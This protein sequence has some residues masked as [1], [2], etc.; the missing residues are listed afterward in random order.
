VT[1]L[2]VTGAELVISD[3]MQASEIR[4]DRNWV[5]RPLSCR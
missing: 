4:F 5:T 2:A 1:Q 3:A